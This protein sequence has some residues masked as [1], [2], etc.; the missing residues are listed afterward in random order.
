[1]YCNVTPPPTP[2]GKQNPVTVVNVAGL[3]ALKRDEAAES[4]RV[5]AARADV[6]AKAVA[7]GKDRAAAWKEAIRA[8][9]RRRVRP[10]LHR[11]ISTLNKRALL[12]KRQ[13][14]LVYVSASALRRMISLQARQHDGK[15]GYVVTDNLEDSPLQLNDQVLR[16][17]GCGFLGATRKAATEKL[18]A[19]PSAPRIEVKIF[20]PTAQAA[21]K[22]ADYAEEHPG[23][24]YICES[25]LSL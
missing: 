21:K 12:F 3:D 8:V 18:R 22:Q 25:F 2:A 15:F 7:K 5:A 9:P 11:R 4:G 10:H 20:R 13:L 19:V 1:M 17:A 23:W 14:L 24:T 6:T 16:V